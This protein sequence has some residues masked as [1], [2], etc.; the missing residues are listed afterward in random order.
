M[1]KSGRRIDPASAR[2]RSAIPRKGDGQLGRWRQ[3]VISASAARALG[4]PFATTPIPPK[5]GP[6][7]DVT[8]AIRG[9]E[10]F[11]INFALPSSRRDRLE[12]LHRPAFVGFVFD[13]PPARLPDRDAHPRVSQQAKA[14]IAKLPGTGER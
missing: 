4:I 5:R 10:A 2:S 12:Q 8:S 7:P 6:N 14:D 9:R 3:I 11:T 1:M 13:P